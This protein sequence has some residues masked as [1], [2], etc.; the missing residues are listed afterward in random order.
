LPSYE[1]IAGLEEMISF[2]KL[3]TLP[4]TEKNTTETNNKNNPAA[5]AAAAAAQPQPSLS[6][7]LSELAEK[8]I[9]SSLSNEFTEKHFPGLNKMEV[10]ENEKLLWSLLV[11]AL[12]FQGKVSIAN[13]Y[14]HS[15]NH[16]F[17][18]LF[19]FFLSP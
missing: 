17:L 4:V 8:P 2:K 9:L 12:Q 18:I 10:A 6:N 5:A 19:F 16:R 1:Y 11:L 13:F 15:V 7:S 3:L 14:F